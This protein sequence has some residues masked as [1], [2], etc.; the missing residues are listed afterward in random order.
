MNRRWVSSANITTIATK[1]MLI[2]AI[3]NCKA[4]MTVTH[5]NASHGLGVPLLNKWIYPNA[6][7]RDTGD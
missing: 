2:A 5:R 4:S 7:K 3:A 6:F 1:I